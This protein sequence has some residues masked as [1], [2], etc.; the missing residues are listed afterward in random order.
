MIIKILAALGIVFI[1]FCVSVAF[2]VI[3][4]SYTDYEDDPEEDA[5]QA[6]YLEEWRKK[7]GEKR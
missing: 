2:A 4:A 5:E 1:F 6:A 7:R 3:M